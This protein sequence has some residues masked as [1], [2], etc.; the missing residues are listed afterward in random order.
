MNSGMNSG[1]IRE[2]DLQTWGSNGDETFKNIEVRIGCTPKSSFVSPADTLSVRNMVLEYTASTITIPSTG[3]LTIPFSALYNWDTTQNLVIQICYGS[4]SSN[5][6]Q[7]YTATIPT[8]YNSMVQYY[9]Y[10]AFYCSYLANVPYTPVMYRSI[11]AVTFKY[12]PAPEGGFGY[13]WAPGLYLSD[14]SVQSPAVYVPHTASYTVYTQGR[15]HCLVRD[16]VHIFVPVH[17]YSIHPK[18]TSVCAGTS[19]SLHVKGGF[20]YQWYQNG[21]K[22]AASLSCR[23]CANP[24]ATPLD[25]TTYQV[26]VTDSVYCGDTLSAKINVKPIPNVHIVTRDTTINYGASIQL[27]AVGANVFSWSPVATLSNPNIVNPLASPTEPTTYIVTGVATDGC[28][29]SDSVTVNINYRGKLFVPSA[30][31]P[32]G[33]GKNDRFKVANFTFEKILEFRIFNRWGQEVF[34]A[35]DNSGWDGTWKNVPQ[36]MGAFEYLIRVGFPDGFIETFKGSVTL[37]R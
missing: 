20:Y 32:N 34:N 12:C 31:S 28:A 10:N 16:S 24:I 21:F 33:D 22:S 17:H 29:A 37:V 3:I 9:G 19:V 23:T 14:S 13:T 5:F 27:A 6:P 36:D 15:N 11:P 30:F 2:M 7:V 18:D 25:T 26:V 1:T 4:T 8:T 35:T